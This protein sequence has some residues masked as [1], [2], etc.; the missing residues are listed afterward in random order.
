MINLAENSHNWGKFFKKS[1]SR[2]TCLTEVP[3]VSK[4]SMLGLISADTRECAISVLRSLIFPQC[5]PF[6]P[7]GRL[8]AQSMCIVS[9]VHWLAPQ[10]LSR[11]YISKS[12]ILTN[13]S[14]FSIKD[15]SK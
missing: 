5:E 2:D 8:K 3:E 15:I 14:Y 13:N 4:E 6:L 10:C 7:S 1:E 11:S 9:R 12:R